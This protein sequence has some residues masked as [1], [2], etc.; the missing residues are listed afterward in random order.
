MRPARYGSS[1]APSEMRPQ[2]GSRAMSSI[3]EK[4]SITPARVA[5]LAEISTARPTSSGSKEQ[6]Q[7]SGMGNTVWKPWIT[8]WQNSSGMCRRLFST[9]ICC[10]CRASPASA[11]M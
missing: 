3:G 4:A 2:R 7:P 8:S 9:A 5:S 11:E 6:A 1:P 10:K